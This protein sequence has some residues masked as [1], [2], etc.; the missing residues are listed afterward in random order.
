MTPAPDVSDARADAWVDGLIDQCCLRYLLGTMSQVT[1]RWPIGVA[2]AVVGLAVLALWPRTPQSS[3][4]RS[5]V[6]AAHT[7]VA[8]SDERARLPERLPDAPPEAEAE[9]PAAPDVVE[10]VD[11]DGQPMGGTW[12]NVDMDAVRAALPDNLYWQMA[13]P[14]TDEAVIEERARER[15][16]WNVE[17]GKVLSG[18]GSEDEIRAY[19]DYKSRL[20]ADYIELATHLLDKY[21]SELPDRDVSLLQLARRLHL[22]RL[23]E[24]PRKLEE[25]F[26]RKRTQDAARAAWLADEAAFNAEQADAAS[27]Q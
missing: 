5:S 20:S 1:R 18:T 6:P 17:Y 23:E 22:A 2:L 14:T 10:D 16:R 8:R 7:K 26:E 21:G 4:E 11:I 12:S 9:V 24:V 13:T 27:G 15:A 19:F 25:A 3:V